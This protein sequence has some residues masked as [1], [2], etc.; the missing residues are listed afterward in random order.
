M[1]DNFKIKLVLQLA[2]SLRYENYLSIRNNLNRIFSKSTIDTSLDVHFSRIFSL[3]NSLESIINSVKDQTELLKKLKN[4]M[5]IQI[6]SESLNDPSKLAK[7]IIKKV[8]SPS[9]GYLI[10]GL[11]D[12]NGIDSIDT[13]QINEL[14]DKNSSIDA[15]ID[16]L[17][18]LV[19]SLCI[20][21]ENDNKNQAR[22]F[23]T[24]LLINILLML[25]PFIYQQIIEKGKADASLKKYE[26]FSLRLDKIQRTLDQIQFN[27][28]ENCIC[29]H[30]C[31][32]HFARSNKS[33]RL[34]R[35][36]KNQDVKIILKEKKW[37]KIS[38][39]D[40][41]CNEYIDGWVQKK[42][43]KIHR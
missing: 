4:Q 34:I 35:I 38:V 33:R 43:F 41:R 14:V 20:S 40:A 18:K 31:Y 15:K 1:T 21:H 39:R 5:H 22:T 3:Q 19:T 42:Y 17:E 29:I 25:I 8:E 32:L 10:E 37:I 36:G 9:I 11:K 23:R 30:D 27:A 16:N 26:A 2:S 28:L 13:Q 6:D 24:N 12:I 7:L